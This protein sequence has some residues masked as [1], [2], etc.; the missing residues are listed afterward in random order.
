MVDQVRNPPFAFQCAWNG[1]AWGTDNSIITYDRL[2]YDDISGGDITD[3]AGGMD[4]ST[5]VFTVGRGFS[6]VWSITFSIYSYSKDVQGNDV[7]LYLNGLR[8]EESRYYTYN[9]NSGYV[10][11]QGGRTLYMRL[12]EGDQ[13]TLR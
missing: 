10:G 8:I 6:G 12:E 9:D 5:G 4:I 2:T 11:S 3:A 1:Y 13:V 7:F